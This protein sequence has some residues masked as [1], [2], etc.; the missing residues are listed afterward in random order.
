MLIAAA[1]SI[2]IIGLVH[3][4]LGEKKVITPLR[5]NADIK[6]YMTR[7]IRVSWHLITLLWFAIAAHLVAMHIW[8]GQERRSFLIIMIAVFGFSA[9]LALI[10]SKGR[11]LSYIGFGLVTIFLLGTVKWNNFSNPE[12][13]KGNTENFEPASYSHWSVRH[14]FFTS[15]LPENWENKD[16]SIASKTM[17]ANL[18][19][20]SSQIPLP[21]YEVEIDPRY[22]EA[23]KNF[24]KGSFNSPGQ[25]FIGLELSTFNDGNMKSK[26]RHFETAFSHIRRGNLRKTQQQ[27]AATDNFQLISYERATGLGYIMLDL[28]NFVYIR[29][30]QNPDRI[31]ETTFISNRAPDHD[32]YRTPIVEGAYLVPSKNLVME[33]EASARGYWDIGLLVAQIHEMANK[34]VKPC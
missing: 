25:E 11:H 16:V 26:M 2:I 17:K 23:K 5:R 3:T 1:I 21:F 4:L 15:K 31:K 33:F 14:C 6:P 20:S 30:R 7:L 8:P 27:P 32:W 24:P 22:S 34:A 10:A 19:I 29:L 13:V 18:T 12:F 28:Q 9:V